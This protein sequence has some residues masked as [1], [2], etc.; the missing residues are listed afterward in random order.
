MDHGGSPCFQPEGRYQGSLDRAR[1]AIER[2]TGEILSR[3][4]SEI[5]KKAVHDTPGE[6]SY[7]HRPI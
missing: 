5:S 7:L 6:T 4:L 1:T 3:T 2:R